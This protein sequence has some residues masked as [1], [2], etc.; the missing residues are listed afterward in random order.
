MQLRQPKIPTSNQFR[1]WADNAIRLLNVP[2][3]ELLR[4]H[5]ASSKNKARAHLY[6]ASQ[7]KLEPAL[8]IEGQLV[9]LSREKGIEIGHWTDFDA[10][11]E[12][13]NGRC[14]EGAGE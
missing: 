6:I 7:I 3:S 14:C 1:A 13:L 2:V 10:A 9:V 8:L 11:G 4:D 12:L 5:R